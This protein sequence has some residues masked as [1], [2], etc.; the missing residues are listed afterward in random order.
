MSFWSAWSAACLRACG[1]FATAIS[2]L[3]PFSGG[4]A[5]Q[6][7][8]LAKPKFRDGLWQF[9]RTIE[10]VR[11]PPNQNLVLSK[12]TDTRCVDP[13]VAMA[14]IFS[15]ASI[16]SCRSDSPQLFGNQYIFS[17][18][19]DFMG[20][21]STVLTAESEMSYTE[22]NQLASEPLPKRDTVV[23]RRVGDCQSS[24]GTRTSEV[25]SSRIRER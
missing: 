6:A 12:T 11:R 24:A 25:S 9:E 3:G 13:N 14:G 21:V 2:A 19:C 15:S 16:G 17:N 7:E 23:A 22:V 10:Y 18:R 4:S 8:E 20:P 5:A 1:V